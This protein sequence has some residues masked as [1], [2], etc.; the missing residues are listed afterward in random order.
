MGHLTVA[1]RM[2]LERQWK[3]GIKHVIR[4]GRTSLESRIEVGERILAEFNENS[5]PEEHIR[6]VVTIRRSIS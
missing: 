5:V 6:L 4:E 3:L 2:S 1:R